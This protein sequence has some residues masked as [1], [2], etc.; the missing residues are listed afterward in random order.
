M[1]CEGTAGEGATLRCAMNGTGTLPWEHTPGHQISK[2]TATGGGVH[3]GG[4][5]EDRPVCQ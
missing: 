3:D 4:Q 5:Q 2:L 1:A